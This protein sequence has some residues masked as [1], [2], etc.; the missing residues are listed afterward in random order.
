MDVSTAYELKIIYMCNGL[1][2]LKQ[3]V[4]IVVSLR[5][6]RVQKHKA[7]RSEELKLLPFFS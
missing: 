5:A 2:G 1:E 6:F 4:V 3:V 7:T